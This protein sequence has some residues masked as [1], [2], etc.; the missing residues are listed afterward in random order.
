[1]Y[2]TNRT[3]AREEYNCTGN[4]DY[5]IESFDA[6]H[7]LSNGTTIAFSRYRFLHAVENIWNLAIF[8]T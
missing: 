7:A 8:G 3:V 2:R 1:M 5:R 6:L 4:I